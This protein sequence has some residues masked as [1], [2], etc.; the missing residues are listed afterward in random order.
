MDWVNRHQ[1]L[2]LEKFRNPQLSMSE[3]KENEL[4]AIRSM[5]DVKEELSQAQVRIQALEGMVR[6]MGIVLTGIL[7]TLI[8]RHQIQVRESLNRPEVQEIMEAK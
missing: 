3:E 4:K 1:E 6:E 5:F 2:V 8:P 7:P